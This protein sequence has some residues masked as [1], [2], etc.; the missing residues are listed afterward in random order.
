MSLSELI[1]LDLTRQDPTRP[2]LTDLTDLTDLNTMLLKTHLALGRVSNLP[3][4]WTNVLAAGALAGVSLSSAGWLPLLIAMSL[5]YIAGM[6][7]NDACD[8]EHDAEH[9]PDRP[10]PAGLVSRH[11]VEAY[12]LVYVL[13]GFLLVYTARMTAPM[14]QG[15]AS[16]GWLI[17]SIGLV[18]CIIAYDRHH[19]NNPLSPLLMA[20]CRVAV[21][22]TS[23]YTLA[24]TLPPILFLAIIAI[25]AWLTGLTFLAKHEQGMGNSGNR[26]KEHWPLA[27]LSVP[28]VMA[29]SWVPTEPSILLPLTLLAIVIYLAHSRLY[30]GSANHKG[31]AITLMIAG[32]CLVD[33]LFM[34]LIWGISGAAASVVAF[35][36]TLALQRWVRGT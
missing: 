17:G 8:H 16:I 27:L 2:D 20:G 13:T 7:Y 10:I 1:W 9:Q 32:I 29:F 33:G 11:A 26:W 28:I 12:A 21:L 6:Y 24:A 19:K 14:A 23:S 3:T 15:T 5:F 30:K 35:G 18:V 22:I 36:A 25:L 31:G 34:A 4:V